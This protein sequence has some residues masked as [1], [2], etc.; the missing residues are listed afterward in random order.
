MYAAEGQVI[1][2]ETAPDGIRFNDTTRDIQG[3]I[4]TLNTRI[5][6]PSHLADV[7]MAA[8]DNGIYGYCSVLDAPTRDAA[9][10][11]RSWRS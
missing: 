9:E 11:V 4:P 5:D 10:L 1:V 7:V 2:A 6:S 3:L 8:Y